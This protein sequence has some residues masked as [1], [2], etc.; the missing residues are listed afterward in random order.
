MERIVSILLY[1]LIFATSTALIYQGASAFPKK[2]KL[3]ILLIT[4]GILAPSIMAGIRYKVG[5]DF[6]AY[7]EM[8]NNVKAGRPMYFRAIE[9]LSTL[10]I[11]ISAYL[12]NSFLMFFSFSLITNLCFFLAFWRFFKKDK[13]RVALAFLFY[14]CILF[15]TTLNAVRSGVA[16]S[17]V[18]LVFAYLL[19]DWSKTSIIKGVILIIAGAL[20][21]KI[22][23]LAIVFIPIFWLAKFDKSKNNKRKMILW[24]AYFL[25]ATLFPLIYFVAQD[26]LPLGDYARYLAK[27]SG[28]FSVPLA[29]IAM[30]IPIFYAGAYLYK[31]RSTKKDQTISELLYCA[32]F[33][34]P[35]SILVGWLTYTSGISRLSFLLEPLIIMLMAHLATLPA[36]TAKAWRISAVICVSLVVGLMFIRNLNWSKALPYQTIFYTEVSYA[37]KN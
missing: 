26:I 4:L 37:P 34:I 21:H 36:K 29:N 32:T 31:N 24:A 10:I 15:P 1:L 14:L 5:V 11:I 33:Y 22:A 18:A 8:F 16:T 3:G 7:M 9:P 20:F 13:K 2:K 35:L 30:S 19:R 23:L 28:E 27:F 6:S 12:H 17:M 25:A